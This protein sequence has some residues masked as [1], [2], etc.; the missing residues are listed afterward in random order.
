MNNVISGRRFVGWYNGVPADSDLKFNLDTE[1]A[2][3]LGQGNVAIDIAR[4]LL[5]PID[6][7]KVY[8]K[9]SINIFVKIYLNNLHAINH[10]F[11]ILI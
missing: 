8:L 3:V 6:K 4:I 2:V 11:R 5:T 7:L 10:C 1:E 9:P